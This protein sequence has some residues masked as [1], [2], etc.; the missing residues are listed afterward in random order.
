[1]VGVVEPDTERREVLAK[2]HNIPEAMQFK[3]IE[4]LLERDVLA[5]LLKNQ[6]FFL[7]KYR[8]RLLKCNF[9]KF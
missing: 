5:K 1:M 9:I 8:F 3:S 7:R 6:P 2:E 4:E